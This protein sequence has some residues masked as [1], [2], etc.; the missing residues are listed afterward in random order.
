MKCS[1]SCKEQYRW[2]GVQL[3]TWLGTG[4]MCCSST[5]TDATHGSQIPHGSIA[6]LPTW[7]CR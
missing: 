1:R 6:W 5:D 3:E 4:R 7:N 2:L